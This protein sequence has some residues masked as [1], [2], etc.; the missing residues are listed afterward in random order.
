MSDKPRMLAKDEGSGRNGCP[1]V[2]LKDGMVIVQAPEVGV[3]G[4]AN[5]L[6]GE[7]ASAIKPQVILAAAD[8]LRA[9]GW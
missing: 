7:V 2:Y 3:D 6:P 5:V 8:V 1:A 9:E 4:L